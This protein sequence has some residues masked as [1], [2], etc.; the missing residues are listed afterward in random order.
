[1]ETDARILEKVLN[2]AADQMALPRDSVRADSNFARDLGADSLDQVELI[3]AI[4]DQWNI[5]IPETEAEQVTTVAEAVACI[6][7][8]TKAA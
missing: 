3:M 7:R 5:E 2:I 1:M 4:E 6:I 8:H